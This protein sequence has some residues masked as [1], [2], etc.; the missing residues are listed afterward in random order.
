MTSEREWQ[1]LIKSLP[2]TVLGVP[3]WP[4]ACRSTINKNIY[5]RKLLTANKNTQ[6]ILKYRFRKA[7]SVSNKCKNK[8][9]Q[10]DIRSRYLTSGKLDLVIFRGNA[11]QSTGHRACLRLKICKRSRKVSPYHYRRNYVH[12]HTS[13]VWDR[14]DEGS[15]VRAGTVPLACVIHSC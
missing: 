5:K 7:S 6:S 10:C 3:K 12:E 2:S 9:D 15:R 4:L 11:R 1:S 14:V 8:P 13:S